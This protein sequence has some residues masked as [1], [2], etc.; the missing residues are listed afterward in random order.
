VAFPAIE[1]HVFAS[2][3]FDLERRVQRTE[4]DEHLSIYSPERSVVDAMRLAHRVGRDT[5]LHALNRYLRRPDAQPRRLVAITRELGGQR[6]LT[7][8]L[9]AVMS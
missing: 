9:E 4:T 1:V 7:E 5:A 2:A 6:R 8:A 3:T